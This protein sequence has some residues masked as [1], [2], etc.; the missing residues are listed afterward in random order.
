MLILG[1]GRMRITFKKV[2]RASSTALHVAASLLSVAMLLAFPAICPH[3]FNA[4]LRAPEIR[5]LVIRHT[6]VGQSE[7]IPS[8]DPPA[9]AG[10][11]PLI[12]VLAK[13]QGALSRRA[14]RRAGAIRPQISLTRLLLRLKLAGS[15]SSD[16]LI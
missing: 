15:G 9:N 11:Q 6:A 10:N 12:L 7:Q 13:P 5:H 2:L 3:S 14:T 8:L 4:K 1:R 16:P